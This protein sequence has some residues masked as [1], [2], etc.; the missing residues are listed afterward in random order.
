MAK[1]YYYLISS[2]PE[3]SLTDKDLQYDLVTYRDFI[4]NHLSEQ[5]QSLLRTLYYLFDITNFTNLV[6]E[7]GKDWSQEGYI[8]KGE[9]EAMLK[10]PDTLPDFFR[11][12]HEETSELWYDWT[13]KQFYNNAMTAYIKW[14]KHTPNHFLREWFHFNVNLKNLLVYSNCRRFGL[15]PSEDVLGDSP[16][17]EYLRE[18]DFDIA[19]LN[20]WDF[21]VDQLLVLLDNPNIAMREFLIDEFRWKQLDEMEERYAFGI[22]RLLAFAIRLRIIARN[23]NSED[24]GKK[25][26]NQ[27]MEEITKDYS[28]PEKF[29]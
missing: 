2:L 25:R 23:L 24:E 21:P 18:T 12:F 10:E 6:K 4:R 5:D 28:I 29:N 9:F 7:N 16:E 14:G 27:L 15:T 1:G 19:E 11:E 22:E 3:L 8:S 26:L 17:A 20:W 13:E